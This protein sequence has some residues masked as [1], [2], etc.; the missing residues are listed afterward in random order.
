MLVVYIIF[1]YLFVMFVL[2]R[3]FVPYLGFWRE[4]LPKS[5]PAGFLNTIRR[6]KARNR[7]PESFARAAY[8][9]LIRKYFGSHIF[10][11]LRLDLVF[12]RDIAR[13]WKRS[14]YLPCNQQNWLLY[15]ALIKSGLFAPEEVRFRITI[16]KVGFI[17]QYMQVRL[18][19]KWVLS[20]LG[21]LSLVCPLGSILAFSCKTYIKPVSRDK[22][23]GEVAKRQ[24]QQAATLSFGGSSPSLAFF[25]F[26]A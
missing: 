2:T 20:I 3:L 10:T 21:V 18:N 24:R 8:A 15:A 6:L 4:P 12:S 19:K 17:H 16:T 25:Y 14:G 9:L 22:Y 7:S 26:L 1:G 5:L 11:I 13:M 23:S